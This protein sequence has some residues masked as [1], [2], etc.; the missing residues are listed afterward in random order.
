[1]VSSPHID[2]TDTSPRRFELVVEQFL[3][4]QSLAYEGV[5]FCE[6]KNRAL[7]IFSYSDFEPESATPEMASD[8]I[9]RAK[10]VLEDLCSKS[11]ILKKIAN[12]LPHEHYFCHDHGMGYTVLAEEIGGVFKWCRD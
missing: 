6:D 1:V 8:G 7:E 4:G 10:L 9:R 2:V 11:A 12:K 3:Q 5:A